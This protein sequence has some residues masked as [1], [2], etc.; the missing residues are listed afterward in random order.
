M[1][2][3]DNFNLSKD[4]DTIKDGQNISLEKMKI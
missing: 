2:E 1:T 4:W 3:I